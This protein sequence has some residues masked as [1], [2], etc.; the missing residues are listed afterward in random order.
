[1]VVWVEAPVAAL[2]PSSTLLE[3]W[4]STLQMDG[5]EAIRNDFWPEAL[6]RK[7]DLVSSTTFKVVALIQLTV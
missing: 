1:M 3:I 6:V 7:S 2:P 5:G 4:P